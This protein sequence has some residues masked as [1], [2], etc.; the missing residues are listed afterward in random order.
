MLMAHGAGHARMLR[1]DPPTVYGLDAARLIRDGRVIASALM[2][3]HENELHALARQCPEALPIADVAGD[4]CFDRLTGSLLMRS[5]YRQALG[6]AAGQELVVV[7]ST[8]GKDG[9]FGGAPGLLGSVMAELPGRKVALLLHP[10]ILAA[11]GSRQVGAWLRP[12]LDAGLILADPAE[13]WRPYIAAADRLIGD[14]GSVTAYGAST[15]LPVLCFQTS[16]VGQ[17]AAGS[18]QSIVLGSAAG[19]DVTRPLAAQL[20]AATPIDHRRVAAAIT[21]RPGR[22]AA[23]LRRAMYRLLGLPERRSGW[24]LPPAPLSLRPGS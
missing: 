2:L 8:W 13:D 10:A 7:S 5:G 18:P 24:N 3:S 20:D 6:V 23:L 4:P 17:A 15:G 21:S 9:L 16:S 11:H 1:V 12:G 19:L 22:S 14:R